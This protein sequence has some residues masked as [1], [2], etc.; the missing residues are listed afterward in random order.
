MPR[1]PCARGI[2]ISAKKRIHKQKDPK[3]DR[4]NRFVRIFVPTKSTLLPK[5]LQ[6]DFTNL[7]DQS[8]KSSGSGPT[9]PRGYQ[10]IREL[11]RAAQDALSTK[12]G[13]A[14][15]GFLVLALAQFACGLV[16]CAGIFV[17][18]FCSGAFRLGISDYY[19]DISRGGSP[20]IEKIFSGFNRFV[21]ALVAMLLTVVFT[22]PYMLLPLCIIGYTA[23]SIISAAGLYGYD[24]GPASS[25]LQ[26]PMLL[27]LAS[28]GVFILSIPGLIKGLGYAM[29]WFIMVDEPQLSP[30]EALRK[31]QNMMYGYKLKNFYIW[32]RIAL[33]SI[34]CLFTCGIGFIFLAPY[35][36]T[37]LAKFYDDIK[38]RSEAE[39]RNVQIG[40][41]A[42]GL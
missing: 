18:L 32:L 13:I 8:F 40:D 5:T 39:E 20:R 34:A 16:P 14:I 27:V 12:W 19:L 6:M 42:L 29:T 1:V 17:S 15:G 2:F 30:M 33:L 38:F 11:M 21:D 23:Y 24:S 35:M 41:F 4:R 37:L 26:S 7:D 3:K 31:S 10:T 36:Y 25:L 9:T 22:L 28:F